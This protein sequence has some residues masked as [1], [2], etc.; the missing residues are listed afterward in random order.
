MRQL[1]RGFRASRGCSIGE[2]VTRSQIDRAKQLL[3]SGES[4]KSIADSIGFAS[5]SS[6][7]YAFRRETGQTPGQ[8]ARTRAD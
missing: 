7:T 3:V 8:F 4:I 1:T 6:F 2:Y 5:V